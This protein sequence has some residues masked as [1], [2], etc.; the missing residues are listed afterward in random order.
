MFEANFNTILL[1][2]YLTWVRNIFVFISKKS[3][4]NNNNLSKI[5]QI[6]NSF[7]ITVAL[8]ATLLLCNINFIN[9]QNKDVINDKIIATPMKGYYD[10]N[11]NKVILRWVPENYN[12]WKLAMERG[13][14]LRKMTSAIN[15]Q[16]LSYEEM[17]SAVQTFDT[18]VAGKD[19]FDTYPENDNV[20]FAKSALYEPGEFQLELINENPI[21]KAKSM[22][23]EKKNRFGLSLLA[24]DLST[25]TAELMGLYFIDQEIE[26]GKDYYYVVSI[27]DVTAEDIEKYGLKVGE[28][29][30]S[31]LNNNWIIMKPVEN[32]LTEGKDSLAVL[33]WDKST[34]NWYNSYDIYRGRDGKELEKI[35]KEPFLP[36]DSEKGNQYYYFNKLSENKVVYQYKIIGHT[37]FG[38]DG[39]ES[40]IVSVQGVPSPLNA[41]PDIRDINVINN[42]R[43]S[44][45]WEF[46]EDLL[47]KIRGYKVLRSNKKDGIYTPL[48]E[49]IPAD[50]F[51]FGDE[52]P[53]KTNYYSVVAIDENDYE[54]T[55]TPVIGQLVDKVPP[56]APTGGKGSI[57]KDGST[58]ITWDKNIEDDI[59]GYQ[60]FTSNY[61]DGEYI[62]ITND[63]IKENIF[64]HYTNLGLEADKIYFKVKAYDFH[65][66]HSPFSEVIEVIRPDI[67]APS[68]PLL[69]KADPIANGIQL[70]WAESSSKD[71]IRHELQRKE[72]GTQKWIVIQTIDA[73][74]PIPNNFF[75]DTKGGLM[76]E[77]D[78]RIVAFDDAD[79]AA[80]SRILTAKN[81][82]GG[83]RPDVVN[84]FAFEDK[85]LQ[86]Y[87][88]QNSSALN[89]MVGGL[90]GYIKIYW[91][92]SENDEIYDFQI[93]RSLNN[94]PTTLLKSVAY[95]DAI[96]NGVL[97]VPNGTGKTTLGGLNVSNNPNNNQNTNGLGTNN[98]PPT[99]NTSGNQSL[100][101]Q[102]LQF[103][104][105]NNGYYEYADPSGST[106]V[107][108]VNVK[109]SKTTL[110][111]SSSIGTY[112]NYLDGSATIQIP[113]LA[114][115]NLSIK[116]AGQTTVYYD[117]KT[118]ITVNFT[119]TI[120]NTGV[121]AATNTPNSFVSNQLVYLQPSATKGFEEYKDN[122]TGVIIGIPINSFPLSLTPLTF[123]SNNKSYDIFTELGG[124]QTVNIPTKTTANLQNQGAQNGYTVY[125]DPN[126]SIYVKVPLKGLGTTIKPNATGSVASPTLAYS[127]T[128]SSHYEYT[129][130]GNGAI[131]GIPIKSYVKLTLTTLNYED[132]SNGYDNY[133]DNGTNTMVR[134]PNAN[135][136]TLTYIGN[137]KG[138]E[139][140]EDTVSNV[141]F[142]I[143]NNS[144]TNNGGN[145]NSS[146]PLGKLKAFLVDD[147]DLNTLISIKSSADVKYQVIVRFH[148]GTTSRLC[149]PFKVN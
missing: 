42:D 107:F 39:P 73:S 137:I 111:F 91:E 106:V 35:T 14:T 60:V 22:E 26:V 76:K 77:Y 38:I 140:Y 69:V 65:S 28:T 89:N 23:D 15:G 37:S 68:A 47:S 34:D 92:Y 70:E 19:K 119:G 147:D 148:D 8:F 61:I 55:S 79:L 86:Y 141:Y 112:D 85:N 116:V 110:Q 32:L 21:L 144:Q 25:T 103:V 123:Q 136:S 30:V 130:K 84:P 44:I 75:L 36:N 133:N 128:T 104:A 88:T 80:P 95:Q 117:A 24:A 101:G 121:T 98:T 53:L 83:F 99:K 18:R 2:R 6:L 29:T 10:F 125:N 20:Q 3:F 46:P 97:N 142:L 87:Y 49:L 127:S 50:K 43:I 74:N 81:F 109:I 67:I 115:P 48:S 40:A 63:E 31:T 13:Y 122:G 1:L 12:T 33:S 135:T 9:A 132:T 51:E 66:N 126:T 93:Y 52:Q 56:I 108:P 62:P 11:N 146:V 16:K 41:S 139:K 58:T 57:D 71:V 114:T 149:A 138:F 5:M 45:K 17:Y 4:I 64:Y 78:Y 7:R 100:L 118:D 96:F 129:D 113:T 134:I 105:F 54:L 143:P 72:V 94:K 90:E 59:S 124:K 102:T 131:I 82:A 145:S 120:G 27:R